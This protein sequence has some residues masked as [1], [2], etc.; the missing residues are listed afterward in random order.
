P[1]VLSSPTSI[2]MN[3]NFKQ[4]ESV[5]PKYTSYK[6]NTIHRN[7]AGWGSMHYTNNTGRNDIVLAKVARDE[8]FVYFYVETAAPLTPKTDAGWMRLF[9]DIDSDRN[10][11]WEGYDF[12]INRINPGQKAVL[13]KTDAAWHWQKAGEVDYLVKGNKLEIKVPR[14]MIGAKDELDFGFKWSDNMQRE[15]DVMDFWIN[16]DVAPAGRSNFHYKTIK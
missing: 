16:G 14:S 10:T 15:N 6:G 5:M 9:I 11:G 1:A 12:V 7:S 4:W 2:L 3:G 13:E 8:Q